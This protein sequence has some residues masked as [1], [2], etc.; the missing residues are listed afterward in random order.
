MARPVRRGRA[1]LNAA[2]APLILVRHGAVAAE[3]AAALAPVYDGCRHDFVPLSADG[4]RQVEGLVPV[5]GRFAPAVV[6]ASPYTRTLQTGALL[7][8]GWGCPLRVDLALHDWL[9]ERDGGRPIS[10]GLVAEKVREYERAAGGRPPEERTWE[11][12]DDMR[13]RLR[14]AA[15]R[16]DRSGVAVLV[17]HEAPIKA[18]TGV[19]AVPLASWHRWYPDGG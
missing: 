18:V 4:V 5:L 17:T 13:R 8:A 14:A 11:S 15:R 7:S 2:A 10:A 19:A 3:Q 16:V 9:P 1:Q 6:V 12:D